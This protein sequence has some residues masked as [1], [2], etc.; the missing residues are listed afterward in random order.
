MFF[1]LLLNG[2]I[3]GAIYALIVLGFNLIYWVTKFFN[4]AHGV[5]AVAG[6]YT[7]LFLYKMMKFDLFVS[8]FLGML[9]AGILGFLMDRFIFSYLRKRKASAVSMFVTSLGIFTVVQAVI[10]MIFSSQFQILTDT[11]TTQRTYI[12]FNGVVTDIHLI[13][14]I[15]VV[16]ILTLFH[17]II[18]RTT[19]GKAVKAIGDDAEVAKI[20]GINTDRVIG[21]VFLIGSVIAGLAGILIGFDTGVMP[22]FGMGLLLKGIT[23]SIIGGIGNIYGGVLGSFLLGLVENFGVWKISGEWKDA[24]AFG[25]LIIFLVF[26]PRG[27]MNN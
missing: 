7:V 12:V 25:L 6:A 16:S 21:Y 3:A 2:I 24:I 27:I 17:L 18:N 23:A 4:V 22:T 10:A 20:V 11:F 14:M 8:I 1:Q 15:T 19:F 5:I 13:I 26:R 9:L